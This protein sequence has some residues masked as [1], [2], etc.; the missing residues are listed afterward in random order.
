MTASD[1][2]SAVDRANSSG[3]LHSL[4]MSG[5]PDPDA[6]SAALRLIRQSGGL[7][8]GEARLRDYSAAAAL[9]WDQDAVA[10]AIG[11]WRH[12]GRWLERDTDAGATFG[13]LLS[14]CGR[15]TPY[16]SGIK[17]I[18]SYNRQHFGNSMLDG[19]VSSALGSG[20]DP[21]I[22]LHGRAISIPRTRFRFPE[23][24]A[25]LAL[26][27]SHRWGIGRSED[28]TRTAAKWFLEN[29]G[30]SWEHG[31]GQPLSNLAAVALG[32]ASGGQ[33]PVKKLL[34]SVTKMAGAREHSQA[35]EAERSRSER[36]DCPEWADAVSAA[37][38]RGMQGYKRQTSWDRC[39]HLSLS[40]LDDSPDDVIDHAERFLARWGRVPADTAMQLRRAE[41]VRG[42]A[43]GRR[44]AEACGTAVRSACLRMRSAPGG[45]ASADILEAVYSKAGSLSP[46]DVPTAARALVEAVHATPDIPA[47]AAISAFC[48]SPRST[49]TGFSENDPLTG[50]SLAWT[51]QAL[52]ACGAV[53]LVRPDGD[54]VSTAVD[55]LLER[56]G[57][58][59]D[60]VEAILSI[61]E[62]HDLPHS[63]IAELFGFGDVTRSGDDPRHICDGLRT[64]LSTA[65]TAAANAVMNWPGA[66]TD[67]GRQLMLAFMRPSDKSSGDPSIGDVLRAMDATRGGGNS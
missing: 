66:G 60:A 10:D 65:R 61:V 59:R 47:A 1:R 14:K 24:A 13:V 38:D 28:W 57:S 26:Q 20:P 55:I 36:A 19:L 50:E 51:G 6:L 15:E 7:T 56:C 25:C 5:E 41:T 9:C 4:L 30:E 64:R 12:D 16:G 45:T 2:I 58:R 23:H 18:R 44:L 32:W 40:A 17:L 63:C 33:T 62:P 48:G 49:V 46:G 34:R 21:E 8:H 52:R 42:A 43:I 11:R 27:H 22:T 29:Y 37:G 54:S 35:L 39:L 67:G 31:E 3:L 53:A